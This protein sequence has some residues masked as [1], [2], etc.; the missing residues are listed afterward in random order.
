LNIS[1]HFRLEP[2]IGFASQT[3]SGIDQKLS[4]SA[5]NVE[6]GCGF[7]YLKKYDS[8]NLYSGIRLGLILSHQKVTL[9]GETGKNSKTD[10]LIGPAIGAEYFFVKRFSLGGEFQ[11]IY[12]K[13]G[14]TTL[15]ESGSCY[16]VN[17]HSFN[18]RGLIFIRWYFN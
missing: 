14:K 4:A 12:T 15:C 8:L 1:E 10:V 11:F 7:F 18:T 6:L 2:E 9:D 16:D 3:S 17:S 5:S 13:Y